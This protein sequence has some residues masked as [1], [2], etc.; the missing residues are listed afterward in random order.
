MNIITVTVMLTAKII[1]DTD[2]L[3]NSIM[4]INMGIS[5]R[6]SIPTDKVLIHMTFI[7][8]IMALMPLIAT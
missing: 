8:K 5:R 2:I 1:T 6:S 7:T 3:M 4:I